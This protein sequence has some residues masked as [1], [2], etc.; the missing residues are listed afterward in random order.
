MAKHLKNKEYYANARAEML[1][2]IPED[3]KTILEVGCGV[4]KFSTLL[5]DM[6]KENTSLQNYTLQASRKFCTRYKQNIIAHDTHN[7]HA[8]VR[9]ISCS[10]PLKKVLHTLLSY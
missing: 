9:L 10:R 3:S 1:Q 8:H 5:T 7:I 2:F 4:G 6:G